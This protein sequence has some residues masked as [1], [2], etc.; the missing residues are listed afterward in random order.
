MKELK[1]YYKQKFLEHGHNEAALGWSKGK[2][3]VRFHTLTRAFNLKNKSILDIGCGFGDFVSFAKKHNLDYKNYHGIDLMSEFIEIAKSKHGLDS[4]NKF[5]VKD[6]NE[7][8]DSQFDYAIASGIFGR[9]LY[10]SEKE[11]YLHVEKMIATALS[12]VTES[13]AFDFIS[14]KVEYRT[15]EK[16]FHANPGKIIEIAYKFSKNV[17]LDN[18]VMPFEFSLII[19]KDQ[20]FKKETTVFEKFLNGNINFIANTAI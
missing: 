16:D 8:V 6:A 13:V 17:V 18:S 9:K 2:Q 5:E 10:E 20:S 3:F 12:T 1:E 19:N 4:R 14:D 15:S 7:L 11:N